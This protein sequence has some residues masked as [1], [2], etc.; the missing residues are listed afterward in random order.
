M[1]LSI[2]TINKTIKALHNYSKI[3][4]L[5][6][7]FVIFNNHCHNQITTMNNQKKLTKNKVIKLEEEVI[8]KNRKQILIHQESHL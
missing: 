7:L 1:F 6:I 8:N 4:K 5:I 2:I 3:L